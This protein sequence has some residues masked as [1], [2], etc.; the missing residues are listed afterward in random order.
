MAALNDDTQ[1]PAVVARVPHPRFVLTYGQKSA[2]ASKSTQGKEETQEQKD[3]TNDITPYV[4]SVTYSDNLTGKSDEIEVQLEDAD[5]RWSNAWYPGKGDTLTL[6]IGYEHEPLLPCGTFDIDEIEFAQPPSTVT[7][8]AL[9]TSVATPVRTAENRAFEN[10]TLE[11]IANFVAKKNGQTLKGEIGQVRIERATQLHESDVKFLTR[12]AKEYGYAFKIVGKQLVFTELAKLREQKPVVT[13]S[14][15]DLIS[16]RLTDKIKGV[17]P[18]AKGRYFD[19]KTRE[20]TSYNAKS[21]DKETS[22]DTLKLTVRASSKAELQTK[23][24]AALAEANL[25]QTTGSVTVPGDPRL[26]AGVTFELT[27]CGRLSGTFQISSARHRI[28]RSGYTSDLE[29][30]RVVKPAPDTKKKA[31][32]AK[33]ASK[34]GKQPPPTKTIHV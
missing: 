34:P 25:R 26:V 33:K 31:A 30:Q 23:T 18:E 12:I 4:L 13:L 2:E 6:K 5:G 9:S 19:P 3:I 24:D 32:P 17:Y 7:I 8:R 1:Q 14:V 20:L 11:A 16:I 29:V 21:G 28:S 22:S 27:G 10:T 15:Q